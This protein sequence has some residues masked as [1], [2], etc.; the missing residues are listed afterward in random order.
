M[1]WIALIFA[2]LLWFILSNTSAERSKETVE[3]EMNL[4]CRLECEAFEKALAIGK[5]ASAGPSA[6]GT[7]GLSAMMN[8]GVSNHDRTY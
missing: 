4:Y 7:A 6:G 8:Y 1:Y 2:A 5:P 3:T